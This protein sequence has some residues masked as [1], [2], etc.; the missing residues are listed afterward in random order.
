MGG[1]FSVFLGLL[2]FLLSVFYKFHCRGLLLP[3]LSL[4]Q[5][6]KQINGPNRHCSKVELEMANKSMEQNASCPQAP[7]TCK[8]KLQWNAIS[9]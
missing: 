9:P 6:N 8:S 3:W 7:G 5:F 2:Q 1:C 4:L